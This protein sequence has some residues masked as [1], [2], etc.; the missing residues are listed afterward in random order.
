MPLEVV[1]KR[2]VGV[3]EEVPF[4]ENRSSE[5]TMSSYRPLTPPTGATMTLRVG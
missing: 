1:E 5:S 2:E 4:L 3:I